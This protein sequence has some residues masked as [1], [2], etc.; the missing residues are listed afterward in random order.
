[1]RPSYICAMLSFVPYVC[2][3][4][5]VCV[6]YMLCPLDRTPN[7]MHLSAWTQY[8][9]QPE[10]C[11]STLHSHP[12]KTAT[13][14]SYSRWSSTTAL[15]YYSLDMEAELWPTLR[16]IVVCCSPVTLAAA[17]RKSKPESTWKRGVHSHKQRRTQKRHERLERKCTY[18]K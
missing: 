17:G 11:W 2:R 6:L 4:R 14:M 5:R 16:R 10:L 3:R 1:M 12:Y 15:R 8:N 13:T 9:A 7:A 18:Q